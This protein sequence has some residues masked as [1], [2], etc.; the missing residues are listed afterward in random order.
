MACPLAGPVMQSQAISLNL[1]NLRQRWD[2]KPCPPSKIGWLGCGRG[3]LSARN[4]SWQ[5]VMAQGAS[6]IRL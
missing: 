6:R 3:T 1:R 2:I 5:P 4:R